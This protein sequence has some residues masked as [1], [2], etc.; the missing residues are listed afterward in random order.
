MSTLLFLLVFFQALGAL[1]GAITAV[2]SEL[3]YVRAMRDG[4]LDAAERAYLDGIAK[5]LRFGMPFLLLASLALVIVAYV[6][7]AAPQPALTASY[8]AFMTLALLII[9]TSFALSR[10][11][12]SFALG[13]AG[14]FAAWWFLVFL[15]LGR[16][17]ALS[18]GAAAAL[19][20]VA[21]ALLYGALR[22]AR[23]LAS[24]K[25]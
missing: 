19:Y 3:A 17:P 23:L 9:G 10:R 11:R 4:R 16:L 25:L 8:W 21:A 15:T 2:W 24:L 18:F 7:H 1:V 14:V 13:S 5:G 20:V 22:Y 6:L 12:V